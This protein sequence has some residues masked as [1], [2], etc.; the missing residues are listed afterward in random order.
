[1]MT[2]SLAIAFVVW[3]LSAAA[4]LTF[5]SHSCSQLDDM[6]KEKEQ[7]YESCKQQVLDECGE[8]KLVPSECKTL[9]ELR[10]EK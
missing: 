7:E 10:C 6:I 9:V 8:D 3:V 2:K 1:M 5:V 4:L